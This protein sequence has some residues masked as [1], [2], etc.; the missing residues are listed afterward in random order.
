MSLELTGVAREHFETHRTL[1]GFEVTGDGRLRRLSVE[2]DG[3]WHL[4]AEDPDEVGVRLEHPSGALAS[5]LLSSGPRL[6]LQVTLT[7]HR[8]E[9]V[10]VPGPVLRVEGERQPICWL[11]EASGEIVLPSERGPG[12][13][14]QRRGLCSAG[15][16]PDTAY[17]L[18][19]EPIIPRDGTLSAAWTYEALEGDILDVPG[20]PSWFPF[21]R[22]PELGHSVDLSVPDGLV[23]ADEDVRVKEDE[24]EFEL[25]PPLGLSTVEVWGPGGRTLLEI[26]ARH[27]VERLREKLAEERTVDDAWAYVA[28]RHMMESWTPDDLVDRVDFVLGQL[29]ETPTAWGAVAAHL[30]TQLGLPLE[31]EAQEA[32]TQVLSRGRT[33]DVIVLALH[34][35]VPID[36][37]GGGWPIGNFTEL[38]VE[39]LSRIGYGRVCTS[40]APLRG[41]DVGIAKLFA[42]GL[43]ETE[44]GLRASS[45]AMVAEHRLLCALSLQPSP[46]D[47]AWLSIG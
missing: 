46:V 4:L 23:V 41:R 14:T 39:A 20:E 42:A 27:D 16:E 44:Q 18:D 38:G 7:S 28:V 34:G 35:L 37:L 21:D 40:G 10:T 19:A 6:R 36:L 43:G 13:L 5:V 11:A 1:R 30:A 45:S 2:F 33:D 12:L 8:S 31:D 22:Y 26:G 3:G 32:A 29:L 17:L 47:L 24:G 25:Y 9:A 15:P